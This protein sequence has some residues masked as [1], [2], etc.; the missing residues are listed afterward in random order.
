MKSG[1]F[2]RKSLV[3]SQSSLNDA[4]T[5]VNKQ[6]SYV[7]ELHTVEWDHS[8]E[9]E[10]SVKLILELPITELLISAIQLCIW[11]VQ[12][13]PKFSSNKMIPRTQKVKINLQKH[14]SEYADL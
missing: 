9:K 1:L 12:S 6:Q 4:S 10:T 11:S 8:E 7:S 2:S 3:D 13:L 5:P 14:D